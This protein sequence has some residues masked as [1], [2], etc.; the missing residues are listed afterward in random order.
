MLLQFLPGLCRLPVSSSVQHRQA[1]LC[2]RVSV[3]LASLRFHGKVPESLRTVLLQADKFWQA[4]LCTGLYAAVHSLCSEQS[5]ASV[6]DHLCLNSAW[7]RR[8]THIHTDFEPSG[9]IAQ[10]PPV[11]AI[12]AD[13]TDRHASV[14]K[15]AGGSI[16]GA[17]KLNQQAN[18]VCINWAGGLHHA[19]KAEVGRSAIELQISMA[20]HV[21][22]R[23]PACAVA[24]SHIRAAAA[25]GGAL[26]VPRP[27]MK[28]S[29]RFP[30]CANPSHITKGFVQTPHTFSTPLKPL[31]SAPCAHMHCLQHHVLTS[32]ALRKSPYPKGSAV[33]ALSVLA[34]G[35][36]SDMVLDAV[37]DIMGSH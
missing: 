7:P 3:Q 30:V 34:P 35:L 32:T 33:A 26:Q 27:A 15:Y 22:C 20:Q 25:V 1:G 12:I 19:K 21:S 37:S 2:H 31:S 23:S 13:C 4:E 14:Q 28:A 9:S 5:Y 17:V 36:L 6:G 10:S 8:R 18:D 16:G 24:P 29:S 11:A